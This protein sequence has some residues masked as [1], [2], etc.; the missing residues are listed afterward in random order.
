MAS[1]I[2]NNLKSN[3]HNL[4]NEDN[5]R[6]DH[7]LKNEIRRW[8]KNVS[9]EGEVHTAGIHTALNLIFCGI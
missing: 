7:I 4:Q 8:P 2:K 5:L 1:K 6:N 3:E 9:I